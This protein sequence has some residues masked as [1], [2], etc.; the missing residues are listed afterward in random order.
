MEWIKLCSEVSSV[1]SGILDHCHQLFQVVKTIGYRQEKVGFKAGCA[2]HKA[3]HQWPVYEE[4]N[5]S[6][7]SLCSCNG[8]N[9]RN[10][11]GLLQAGTSE[12]FSRRSFR[13]RRT[14]D[15]LPR[16]RGQLQPGDS[17]TSASPSANTTLFQDHCVSPC[18][19]VTPAPA[20]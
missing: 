7:M 13:L 15:A 20:L 17:T 2:V 18:A 3:R 8:G 11:R 14:D 10:L 19:G 4:R 5:P 16:L 12:I 1:G 6:L 9:R